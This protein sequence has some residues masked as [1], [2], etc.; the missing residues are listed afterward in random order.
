M[1]G[2]AL[3]SF[4]T[5]VI[6]LEWTLFLSVV[7]GGTATAIYLVYVAGMSDHKPLQRALEMNDFWKV[8]PLVRSEWMSNHVGMGTK[9]HLKME[10]M[11]PS[12]SFKIRGISMFMRKMFTM[13]KSIDT[14]VTTSSANAGMAV[15]YCA[16]EMGCRCLIVLDETQRNNRLIPTFLSY[17]AEV[18]F[19]GNRWNDADEYALTKCSKSGTMQYVPMFSDHSIWHGHSLM[20]N[21]M[22]EQID[23]SPDCIVCAVGGG[24]LLMGMMGGLYQAG[25]SRSCKVVAA[26][27]KRCALLQEA[28]NNGYQQVALRCINPQGDDLGYRAVSPHVMRMTRKFKGF[29]PIKSLVVD[30]DDVLSACTMFGMKERV[31]IEPLCA[32]AVA[33]VLV[34]KDYFSQFRNIV[35]I[36]CGGNHVHFDVDML[37]EHWSNEEY[38]Y[39]ESTVVQKVNVVEPRS[40]DTLG[41]VD[42]NTGMHPYDSDTEE[43]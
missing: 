8:T 43:M 1:L 32:V 17:G 38:G 13:T 28:I 6:S 7:I 15:A 27:S 20:V 25:W 39:E 12:G 41:D 4:Y 35:I 40:L 24:G 19:A 16:R 22:A 10:A 33:A 37:R 34:N 26:Q 36:V 11:Q 31:L 2:M 14:F 42:F 29:N 3:A 30:D 21:E 9:V 5:W 23:R 18:E